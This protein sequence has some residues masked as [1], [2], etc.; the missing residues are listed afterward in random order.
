MASIDARATS[1]IAKQ[2]L[3]RPA[4]G[5]QRAVDEDDSRRKCLLRK[6]ASN[7]SLLLGDRAVKKHRRVSACPEEE[8]GKQSAGSAG[9]SSNS[10]DSDAESV[11]V[12]KEESYRVGLDF[13]SFVVFSSLH[14]TATL[15]VASGLC[16]DKSR[17]PIPLCAWRSRKELRG[18]FLHWPAK[19]GIAAS[20]RVLCDL[21]CRRAPE[22][23][24]HLF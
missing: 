12:Q 22:P 1:E 17:M 19:G 7:V 5:H 2:G 21:C 11:P 10:R 9:A 4:R 6:R 16:H 23:L 18:T 20:G 14:V 15:H 8:L 13:S 24:R 3:P